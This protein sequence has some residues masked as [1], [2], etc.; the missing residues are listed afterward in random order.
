MIFIFFDVY[1]SNDSLWAFYYGIPLDI[2]LA[3][4]CL[5]FPAFILI[6]Y[7][8]V[9]WVQRHK[10][11]ILIVYSVL[12]F[13][14]ISLIETTSIPLF[15]EWGTT[16][17]SRGLGYLNYV[18]EAWV[19]ISSSNTIVFY[20]L[21]ILMLFLGIYVLKRIHTLLFD[22]VQNSKQRNIALLIASF[23][24]F[25]G[26]RGGVQGLPIGVSSSFY[27][28]NQSSNYASVN[29]TFYLFYDLNKK[30]NYSFVESEF[31][32]QQLDSFY[33][34]LLQHNLSDDTIDLTNNKTPNIVLVLLEGWPFKIIDPVME[35]T[36]N[37]SSLKKEGLF[38]DHIYSSGYRTDQGLLSILSGLPALPDL[39]IM[40]DI[41]LVDQFPSIIQ[42]YNQ[43]NYHTSF[44]YG[45]SLDFSNLKNYFYHNE[46]D[47]IIGKF[48]F[49]ENERSLEWGV[50]DHLVFNRAITEFNQI[51][52]PFFSCILTLSSHQ[53]F[54][55][56]EKRKFKSKSMEDMYRSAVYYLDKSINAF[57]EESKKTIWFDNT[58]F[59]FVADHGSM[60]VEG[61]DYDDHERF[62]I[63]LL[64][65]GKPLKEEYHGKTFHNIGNHHDIPATLMAMSDIENYQFPFSQN[66][67]MKREPA[68]WIKDITM[69]W[70]T[71]KSNLVIDHEKNDFFYKKKSTNDEKSK[72]DALE[73]YNLVVSYVLKNKKIKPV[74]ITN[75]K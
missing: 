57:I 31:S 3:S 27:S 9:G 6:I 36:P 53:P 63:P 1:D 47:K 49:P 65:Y 58:I 22:S 5:I 40:S 29:K 2:S 33:N 45:G 60:Y 64:I 4:Y 71:E 17:N 61:I 28:K 50:P 30:Y 66:L 39:N 52:K 14:I 20:G 72:S 42:T 43:K 54:D 44:I 13:T 62:H 16:L 73:Y 26:L 51:K 23:L 32:D 10:N 74:S 75:K 21:F 24:I 41:N 35:S 48:D 56:P 69:G 15:K 11:R 25:I 19:S 18:N 70:L 68:Y 34:D 7:P 37:F 12:I 67:L 46:T 38:F 59:L 55:I 8:F